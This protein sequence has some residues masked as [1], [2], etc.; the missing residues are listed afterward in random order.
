MHPKN[1]RAARAPSRRL[2]AALIACAWLLAP[3]VQ[4]QTQ[5]IPDA[6][7]EAEPELTAPAPA[8]AAAPAAMPTPMA[9]PA[10][11]RP[12]PSGV[13]VVDRSR[14]AS[15]DPLP[16]IGI[17]VPVIHVDLG[18][19]IALS[20]GAD[21]SRRYAADGDIEY[22]YTRSEVVTEFRLEREY[23]RE[24]GETDTSINTDEYDANIKWKTWWV[25]NPFYTYWSPRVRYNRF[26]FFQSSQAL[27]VGLGRRYVPRPGIELTVEAGTGVR[28]AHRQDG[29][30][31]FEGLSTLAAKVDADVTD[32]LG[33]KFNLVNERSTRE[34]Y[35]TVTAG[36]RNKLTDRI[37]LKYELSYRKSFPFDSAPSIADSNFDAGITY[38]F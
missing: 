16:P 25:D 5:T 2:P 9:P 13:E 35:R 21:V 36:L 4:A 34:N 7:P 3:A 17:E 8:P 29:D 6:P 19:R 28:W 11:T 22:R 30:G 20:R 24:Q 33:F 15:G 32:T 31:V 26:G 14:P 38:R 37:W 10:A 1:N 18:L 23:L 27:R 12:A